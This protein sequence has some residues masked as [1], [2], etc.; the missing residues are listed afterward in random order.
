MQERGGVILC[1]LL[2]INLGIFH[3][4]KQHILV[5]THCLLFKLV[6]AC[7]IDWDKSYFKCKIM[8]L[9]DIMKW[10]CPW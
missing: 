8:L 1:L 7:S 10:L 4:W 6:I 9:N 5:V 3:S 2:Y